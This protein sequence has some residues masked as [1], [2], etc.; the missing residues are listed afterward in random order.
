MKKN[1]RGARE[2]M[3]GAGASHPNFLP[4]EQREALGEWYGVTPADYNEIARSASR[5]RTREGKASKTQR[6]KRKATSKKR[7]GFLSWLGLK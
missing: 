1:I 3:I 7:R 2:F 5:T 6:R 4:A